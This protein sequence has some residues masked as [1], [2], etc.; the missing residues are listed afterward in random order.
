MES[1]A[2]CAYPKGEVFEDRESGHL[3]FA[4]KRQRGNGRKGNHR[5]KA[6][7]N[8]VVKGE[9]AFSNCIINCQR[10]SLIIGLPFVQFACLPGA[11]RF[12]LMIASAACTLRNR[13]PPLIFVQLVSAP[14]N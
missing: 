5:R 6:T 7:K 12:V 3:F 13:K 10:P 1:G 8:I 9:E 4:I 11:A 2:L 14:V